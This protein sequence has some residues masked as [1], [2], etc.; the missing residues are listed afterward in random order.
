[1]KGIVGLLG[2]LLSLVLVGF[3]VKG[4]LASTRQIAPMLPLPAESAQQ[5]AASAP[6]QPQPVQQQYKQA[7][8][9]ALQQPRAVPGE[10]QGE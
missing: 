5:G 10:K 1:M 2:L 7:L 4:Q 3:L 9:G 8:E 6:V